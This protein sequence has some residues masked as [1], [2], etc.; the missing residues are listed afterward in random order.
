MQLDL[1]ELK[2]NFPPDA[3]RTLLQRSLDQIFNDLIVFGNAIAS[4]DFI[5][6][7]QLMHRTR[8]L[9]L[10]LGVPAHTLDPI[11]VLERELVTHDPAHPR[12]DVYQLSEQF[13]SLTVE[14]GELLT[15]AVREVTGI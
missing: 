8:G 13:D 2:S 1:N 10:F 6:A 14:L 15:N 4:G 11:Q 3:L 9:A 7:A 12:I 5:Q